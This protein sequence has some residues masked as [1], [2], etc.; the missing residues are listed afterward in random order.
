VHVMGANFISFTAQ[1]CILKLK[2]AL[3]PTAPPPGYT[4][5]DLWLHKMSSVD[6]SFY[7]DVMCTVQVGDAIL[8]KSKLGGTLVF[9]SAIVMSFV[10]VGFSMF[11]LSRLQHSSERRPLITEVL[12]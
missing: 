12:K 10:G 3:C 8:H 11:S 1:I 6:N 5:V 4:T 7:D 9:A 2:G